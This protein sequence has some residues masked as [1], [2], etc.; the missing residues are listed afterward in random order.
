MAGIPV[1]KSERLLFLR[2]FAGDGI[3][4][5]IRAKSPGIGGAF[6]FAM[7]EKRI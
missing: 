3:R 2:L 7:R 6:G 1:F 4:L 5:A